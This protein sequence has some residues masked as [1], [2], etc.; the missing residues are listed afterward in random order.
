MF[1]YIREW[2]AR[3]AQLSTALQSEEPR[4]Q[5]PNLGPPSREIELVPKTIPIL[6]AEPGYCRF[7]T[8]QTSVEIRA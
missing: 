7:S 1:P 4:V 8:Q 5:I 6:P 3:G 2:V